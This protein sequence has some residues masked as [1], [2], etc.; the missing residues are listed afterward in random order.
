MAFRTWCLGLQTQGPG[1]CTAC[2]VGVGELAGPNWALVESSQ[3]EGS[4]DQAASTTQIPV[5][6]GANVYVL[7]AARSDLFYT[8]FN[9][10]TYA[11]RDFY[12]LNRACS[13]LT[14]R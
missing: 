14:V 6:L 10:H 8:C 12:L 13:L 1:S 2:T 4:L 9:A 11:D 7:R 5:S 3:N